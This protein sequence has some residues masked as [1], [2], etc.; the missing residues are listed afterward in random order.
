M[1]HHHQLA[2]TNGTTIVGYLYEEEAYCPEC[3]YELLVPYDLLDIPRRSTEALLDDLAVRRGLD[4]H[5][6]HT[7]G[8]HDF[9]KPIRIADVIGREYC[10]RCGRLL[11]PQALDAA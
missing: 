10:V 1:D 8:S 4:R 6:E 5:D 3:I 11:D 9:P 7:F 2:P